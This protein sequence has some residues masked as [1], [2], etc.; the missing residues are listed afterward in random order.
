[1]PPRPPSVGRSGAAPAR[2]APAPRRERAAARRGRPT[3]GSPPGG[4]APPRRRTTGAG[5]RAR[6]RGRESRPSR[7]Y[8]SANPLLV[9]RRAGMCPPEHLVQERD[10]TRR[11]AEVE[12]DGR[13]P[14]AEQLA[15]LGGERRSVEP[16]GLEHAHGP[17][18]LEPSSADPLLAPSQLAAREAQAGH[19][20]AHDV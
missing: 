4:R 6:A 20:P 15:H 19:A 1:G 5:R 9:D 7:T 8:P 16:F 17:E 12:R 11:A 14:K 18:P 3:G 2:P 13:R 10:R